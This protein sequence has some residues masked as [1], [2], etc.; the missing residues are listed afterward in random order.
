MR[1]FGLS[2]EQQEQ[3]WVQ[4]RSGESL[5]LIARSMGVSRGSMRRYVEG[6]GGVRPP[7]R[8]RGRLALTAAEREEISRGIAAGATCRA[9]ARGLGRQASTISRELA[10]NGG[11]EAYRAAAADAA[12]DVRALRP[13]PAKLA[14]HGRLRAEVVRGLG[15]EWSPQQIAARLVV[16]F[17]DDPDMRVSHETIYL[18]LF[19][20]ARGGLARELTRSLRTG[21]ATRHPRGAKLPT[22][23]GQLR[24]MLPIS[25]RPA[26][27]EDR[28][29]PGHWE[30]DLVLGKLP[31]AVAT[32]VERTSRLV[33]LVALPEGKKA[34]QVH[35]ALA[36]AIQRVPA[37]LRRSLTWDQ[38][39]EMAEHAQ[40][41]V[42]TGVT[43]Y[44]C[45]PKSPWQRGS[46]E[47]TNGLLRQYLPKGADLR[48]FTQDDLDTIAARLNGRPRQ[49]LGWKTPAEAFNEVVAQTR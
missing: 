44:F 43:V 16:D 20:Q 17:P 26:E 5:R 25:A 15:L 35:P 46:N 22:G 37:Q 40:F 41:T 34:E 48:T 2:V 14:A 9:I 30:G 19:V 49:T 13:K 3:L 10:R 18:T 39:K 47:N 21:R 4:W 7:A 27:V 23:R 1:S 38:G 11:R 45:D 32:L 36:A 29:V 24:D 6:C 8:R 42:A 12:A 28:A 33:A 31:S